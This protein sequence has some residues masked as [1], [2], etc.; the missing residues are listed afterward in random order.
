MKTWRVCGRRTTRGT[1]AWTYM[2]KG[3][4]RRNVLRNA[5]ERTGPPLSSCT[6]AEDASGHGTPVL[7]VAFGTATTAGPVLRRL[8][9]NG[10]YCVPAQQA[11][12]VSAT[13]TA[14]S[15]GAEE[16]RPADALRISSA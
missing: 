9:R 14:V 13:L 1:K 3:W 5:C 6:G 2:H 7:L 4:T 11:P 10:A 16:D 12:A 8:T 15:S